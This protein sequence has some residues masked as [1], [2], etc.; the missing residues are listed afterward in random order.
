MMNVENLN[1]EVNNFRNAAK[2]FNAGDAP[3]TVS[4]LNAAVDA[5]AEMFKAIIEKMQRNG[6]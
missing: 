2:S 1:N 6:D 3:V 5:A 4:E